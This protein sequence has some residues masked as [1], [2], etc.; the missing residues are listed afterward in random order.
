MAMNNENKEG[1]NKIE[2]IPKEQKLKSAKLKKKTQ[3]LLYFLY[4]IYW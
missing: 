4:M 3:N 1:E 2:A